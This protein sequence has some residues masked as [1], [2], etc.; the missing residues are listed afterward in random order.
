MGFWSSLGGVISTVTSWAKEVARPIAN[1]VKRVGSWIKD[2]ELNR[3]AV[4]A[5]CLFAFNFNFPLHLAV[6]HVEISDL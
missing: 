3:Y 4:V 5:L 1:V 6:V 2:V